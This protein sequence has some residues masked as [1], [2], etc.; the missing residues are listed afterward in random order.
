M[1]TDNAVSVAG[2]NATAVN[3]GTLRL[4][5]T[6]A[7]NLPNLAGSDSHSDIINHTITF[8][9]TSNQFSELFLGGGTL[10]VK[11]D[12]AAFGAGSSNIQRCRDRGPGVIAGL[13]AVVLGASLGWPVLVF[14]GFYEGKTLDVN[15]I[16]GDDQTD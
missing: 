14:T 10:E 16:V 15:L 6:Q 11:G 8:S 7:T 1:L 5:F 3:D 9:T 4:D 13:L 12:P 2:I